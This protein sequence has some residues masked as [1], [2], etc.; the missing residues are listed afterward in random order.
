MNCAECGRPVSIKDG[1]CYY[2][3]K[4]PAENEADVKMM[5]IEMQRKDEAEKSGEGIFK[6]TKILSFLLGTSYATIA[7]LGVFDV[8]FFL[9]MCAIVYFLNS[10]T[11]ESGFMKSMVFCIFISGVCAIYM[12]SLGVDFLRGDKQNFSVA[13]FAV[14]MSILGALPAILMIYHTEMEKR[15]VD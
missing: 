14:F 10:W 5:L 3:R 7:V 1:T 8:R 13:F 4:M 6:F 12:L 2:C 9:F 11:L 15:K